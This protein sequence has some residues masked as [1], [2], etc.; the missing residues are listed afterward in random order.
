MICVNNILAETK[1]LL[2]ILEVMQLSFFGEAR[3]LT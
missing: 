1:T 3:R 2:K